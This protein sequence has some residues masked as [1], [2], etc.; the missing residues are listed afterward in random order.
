MQPRSV[1][2]R[3]NDSGRRG[4]A[5]ERGG[6]GDRPGYEKAARLL[7]GL[8]LTDAER[9]AA[10]NYGAGLIR[11]ATKALEGPARVGQRVIPA[12]FAF[13]L[14]WLEEAYQLTTP[15]MPPTR[16]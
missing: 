9:E 15:E 10:T 4:A 3:S 7:A 11:E 1:Q 13:A 8:D 6:R 16:P 12:A 14:C 2:R 5:A